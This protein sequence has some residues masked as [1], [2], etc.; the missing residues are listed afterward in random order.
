MRIPAHEL[1]HDSNRSVSLLRHRED[2]LEVA[3]VLLERRLE[4]LVQVAVESS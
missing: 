4:V 3:I 1:P 2:D